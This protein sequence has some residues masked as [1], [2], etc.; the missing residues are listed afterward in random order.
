MDNRY[1]RVT[2]LSIALKNLYP[3]A[4]S[5]HDNTARIDTETIKSKDVKVLFES[6]VHSLTII[7]KLYRQKDAEGNYI[8]QKEDY[9]TALMLVS[10][11]FAAKTIHAGH[12]VMEY[13]HILLDEIG[14]SD[15]FNRHDLQRLTGKAKSSCNRIL[16]GLLELNLI[17]KSGRGYRQLNQ[18]ELIP[19][20]E[21]DETA[22]IWES[23]FENFKDFKGFEKF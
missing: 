5:V 10:P 23:V 8:S 6:L 19:Q 16:N 3:Y 11:L 15:G 4:T 1:K 12:N 17:R 20:S 21:P 18:Y 2:D 9:A 7:N 22:G 14:F 13:Y